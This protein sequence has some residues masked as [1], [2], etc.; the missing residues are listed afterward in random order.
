MPAQNLKRLFNF[1]KQS[2][3]LYLHENQEIDYFLKCDNR[4]NTK[5]DSPKSQVSHANALPVLNN[6][7]ISHVPKTPHA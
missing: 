2:P 6:T 3:T 5:H 7:T 4:H 1:Y